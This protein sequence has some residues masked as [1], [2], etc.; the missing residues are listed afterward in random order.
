MPP[1]Y[2][3]FASTPLVFDYHGYSNQADR[4]EDESGVRDMA[5]EVG[6]IAVFPE[7]LDDTDANNQQAYSWNSVGTVA[8]PGPAGDTCQW[9]DSW[10]GYACHTS[11]RPTRGCY[12]NLYAAGCDCSTCADDVLFTELMLNWLEDELCIDMR[13]VHVTG[14]SNGGM[15]A[16]QLAQSRLGLRIAS[17]AP[18]CASPLLG[19]DLRPARPM[20]V[21]SIMGNNDRIIP[22]NCTGNGCGPSG[23]TIS[24]DGFYY[25]PL[26]SVMDTWGISND[27]VGG[28]QYFPTRYDGQGQFWCIAAAGTCRQGGPV[29]RCSF[30]GGHTWPFGTTVQWARTIWEFFANNP[31]VLAGET[32]AQKQIGTQQL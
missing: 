31:L 17:I 29:V 5:N 21:M 8:S 12:S 11:C 32:P 13:R 6:F 16:Y 9:A 20:A 4:H 15:M 19:F 26:E 2:D 23:S 22:G 25:A 14:F 27:C 7:G 18:L 10:A 24:S 1:N 28:P 30:A 3:Q